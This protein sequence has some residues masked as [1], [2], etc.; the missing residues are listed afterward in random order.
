MQGKET[1]T[2]SANRIYE[3]MNQQKCCCPRCGINFSLIPATAVKEVNGKKYCNVCAALVFKMGEAIST[4]PQPRKI[5]VP[6][7]TPAA[8]R[9]AASNVKKPSVCARCKKITRVVEIA[10]CLL[11]GGFC[12]HNAKFSGIA[13][14]DVL[15]TD[16]A[17]FKNMD[18]GIS[19]PD[20]SA[21]Y[22]F[23]SRKTL[24]VC[25]LSECD[26]IVLRWIDNSDK[27]F[28]AT[29]VFAEKVIEEVYDNQCTL[30]QIEN[31]ELHSEFLSNWY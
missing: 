27:S 7:A 3:S 12:F 23:L 2:E 11:A 21:V 5:S 13:A 18:S 20:C 8:S 25:V 14:Y 26:G 28:A 15:Y 1:R 29:R 9:P 6:L 19:A 31:V 22:A 24:R 17:G 16:Y 10:D 4:Q 30:H